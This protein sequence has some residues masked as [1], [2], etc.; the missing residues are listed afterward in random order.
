M[1]EK[2]HAK[3]PLQLVLG[4]SIGFCFGFLL[5]KG[6]VTRYDIIMGQ[7]LLQDFWMAIQQL[8]VPLVII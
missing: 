6:G 8:V 3:R 7:L 1:L 4:L 5:Q 2:I